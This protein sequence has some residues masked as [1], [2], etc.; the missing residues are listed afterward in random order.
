MKNKIIKEGWRSLKA[1]PTRPSNT[2]PQTRSA[3]GK[4][5]LYLQID[6]VAIIDILLSNLNLVYL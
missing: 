5:M 4:N 2:G 6:C 3:A 1:T